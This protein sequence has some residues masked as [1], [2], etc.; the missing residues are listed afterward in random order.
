[1][2][3]VFE[4]SSDSRRAHSARHFMMLHVKDTA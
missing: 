1:M 3:K 4:I 2:G